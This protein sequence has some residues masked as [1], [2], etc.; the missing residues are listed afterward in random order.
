[1]EEF[2]TMETVKKK[3]PFQEE[4][5]FFGKQHVHGR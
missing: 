2:Y 4:E 5:A 3:N 1:M